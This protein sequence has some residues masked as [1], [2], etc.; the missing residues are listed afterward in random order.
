M[1]GTV[2]SKSA[3]EVAGRSSPALEYSRRPKGW[4]RRRIL[5][6]GIPSLLIFLI[7]W[8]AL[9]NR[10]EL[11]LRAQRIYWG[12]RCATHVIPAGTVLVESDPEKVKELLARNPDYVEDGKQW[13]MPDVMQSNIRYFPTRAVYWPRSFRRYYPLAQTIS[14]LRGGG[15]IR[16]T[17][18]AIAFMGE[19]RSPLG[20]KRLVVI[21]NAEVNALVAEEYIADAE[22]LPL[23]DARGNLAHVSKLM[24]KRRSAERKVKLRLKPGVRDPNDASHIEF[25]YE[26]GDQA[27]H[28]GFIDVFLRDDEKLSVKFRDPGAKAA[29]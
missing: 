26:A 4:Y 22:I 9:A 18:E 1:V 3:G 14:V 5:R 13:N 23:P 7:A 8:T 29:F 20:N 6:L 27:E 21:R 25:E 2:E 11:A 15:K 17:T 12:W 24:E 19:R 16:Q 10:D 28:R